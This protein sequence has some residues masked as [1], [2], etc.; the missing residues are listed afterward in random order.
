[1][2]SIQQWC[3]VP[4]LFK[5]KRFGD[6]SSA[7]ARTNHEPTSHLCDATASF[8]ALCAY[9]SPSLLTEQKPA[10]RTISWSLFYEE[11]GP[12]VSIDGQRM[13]SLRYALIL[14]K[15]GGNRA[16]SADKRFS[17]CRARRACA[18]RLRTNPSRNFIF[19]PSSGK[20]GAHDLKMGKGRPLQ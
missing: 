13:A 15:L 8:L 10:I 2:L 11:E 12:L 5:S 18:R 17:S 6:S 16:M 14:P 9:E 3:A 19:T 7:F 20:L 1:F 4:E